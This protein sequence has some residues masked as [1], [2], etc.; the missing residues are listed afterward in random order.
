MQRK[1]PV[2]TVYGPLKTS[3][4][5][6]RSSALA[7][8]VPCAVE[9]V[10]NVWR[11]YE[12][13]VSMQDKP[14]DMLVDGPLFCTVAHMKMVSYLW[15]QTRSLAEGRFCGRNGASSR[16]IVGAKGIGKTTVLRAFAS[17]CSV[18]FPTVACI[19]VDYNSYGAEND[20]AS[21][22]ALLKVAA[23]NL[24]ER[25]YLDVAPTKGP[26]MDNVAK[27]IGPS[28][29]RVLILVDEFDNL[30]RTG[31]REDMQ[32]TTSAILTNLARLGNQETGL[33]CTFLCGSSSSI[34]QLISRNA[35]KD[36]YLEYPVLHFA[37]NLNET[38]YRAVHIPADLVDLAG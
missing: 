38:K 25:G 23:A 17:V 7:A 18:I 32:K 10:D 22:G 16:T 37:P 20:P 5:R 15:G 29:L 4:E 28:G 26:W 33:F 36:M 6:V 13:L 9:D 19:V 12:H 31:G 11:V 2:P 8:G 21:S 30:Y 34:P 35:T 14:S 1:A 24:V 3:S 27:T